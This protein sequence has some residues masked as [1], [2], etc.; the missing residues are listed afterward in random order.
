MQRRLAAFKILREFSGSVSSRFSLATS[1][2]S[3]V[4]ETPT[5]WQGPSPTVSATLAPVAPLSLT[6]ARRFCEKR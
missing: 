4:T 1:G 2:S 6:L 5:E 3:L